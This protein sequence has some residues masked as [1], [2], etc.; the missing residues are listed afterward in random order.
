MNIKRG[1]KNFLTGAVSTAAI[2][3]GMGVMDW[4]IL[5]GA[6][7]LGG[8]G[9]LAGVNVADRLKRKKEQGK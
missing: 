6:A 7:A 1:A 2:P 4:R 3:A 5:A 9:A 8:I